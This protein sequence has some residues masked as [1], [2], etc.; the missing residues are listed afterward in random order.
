MSVDRICINPDCFKPIIRRYIES[1]RESSTGFKKRKYC[2]NECRKQHTSMKAVE[3]AKATPAEEG[4]CQVCTTSFFRRRNED[5][6]WKES[7]FTFRKQVTCKSA[8]CI[9]TARHKRIF[10]PSRKHMTFE[11]LWAKRSPSDALAQVFISCG[12]RHKVQGANNMGVG[13]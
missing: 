10:A 13:R 9:A 5:G 12:F 2:N 1:G 8:E 6:T 11:N 7:L 3:K 4:H